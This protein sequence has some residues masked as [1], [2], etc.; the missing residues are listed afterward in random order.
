MLKLGYKASAEQFDPA[1]LLHFSVLAE[2]L[3]FDSVFTFDG[4]D[5][6]QAW[7]YLVNDKMMILLGKVLIV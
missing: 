2:N 3:G 7:S 4:F 6:G 1:T 5:F